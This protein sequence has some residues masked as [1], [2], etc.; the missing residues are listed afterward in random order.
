[1]SEHRVVR[2]VIACWF[3]LGASSLF[4]A[5]PAVVAA[6]PSGDLVIVDGSRGIVNVSGSAKSNLINNFE[7]F[8]AT[9][10]TG[11]R[12]KDG[13]T[14]FVTLRLRPGVG[15]SFPR[16]SRRSLTGKEVGQWSLRVPGGVLASVAIDPNRQIAYCSDSHYGVIYKLDLKNSRASFETMIRIRDPGT[17]GPVIFDAKRQRLLVGDVK[18][19]RILAVT[20]AD[21]RVEV[22]LDRGTIREPIALALDPA[23]DRLY[24]AD[25]TKERVW[26]GNLAEKRF[27]PQTFSRYRF[28]DPCGVAWSKGTLWVIDRGTKRLS[29][30]AADG[31]PLKH[32]GM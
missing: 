18:Q 32:I 29:Q 17:L 11:V 5:D 21:K 14:L 20:I 28:R 25:P 12:L 31:N 27:T 24:V 23:T 22:L 9:D 10:L 8:E 15:S 7:I 13:D 6:L 16:L 2:T 3:L 1:M 19:G 4:A 26:V 30:F